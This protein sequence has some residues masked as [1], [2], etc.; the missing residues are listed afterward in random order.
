M[1][2]Y[3]QTDYGLTV[4]AGFRGHCRFPGITD[5]C[6]DWL[7]RLDWTQESRQTDKQT[8]RQIYVFTYQLV[9]GWVAIFIVAKRRSF[10]IG[11]VVD[12][13]GNAEDNA[14]N[15]EWLFVSMRSFEYSNRFG[16][17]TKLQFDSIFL[18]SKFCTW[19]YADN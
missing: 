13:D 2:L 8:N 10:I 3:T 4:S 6:I 17:I 15:E 18:N 16:I 9:D 14:A 12:D 19:W 7:D 11:V 1:K 5:K